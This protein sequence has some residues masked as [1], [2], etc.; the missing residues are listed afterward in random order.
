MASELGQKETP[1]PLNCKQPRMGSRGQPTQNV[2][3]NPKDQTHFRQVSDFRFDSIRICPHI[4]FSKPAG[5]LSQDMLS[6]GGSFFLGRR[7][8]H[9]I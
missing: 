4:F 5:P 8:L 6:L 9:A 2:C 1:G 3:G 7:L